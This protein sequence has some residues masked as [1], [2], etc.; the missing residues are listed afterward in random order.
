MTEQDKITMD[1]YGISSSSKAVYFYKDHK[2][3]RLTDAINY[4]KIDIKRAKEDADPT[5]PA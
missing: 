2:Y 1:K 4:A 3:E 5:K